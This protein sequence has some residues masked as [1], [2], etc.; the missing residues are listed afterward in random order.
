MAHEKRLEEEEAARIKLD[1]EFTAQ[2]ETKRQEAIKR[3]KK[4]QYFETDL[5]KEFHSR[6]LLMH[7]LQV[8]FNHL[9]F[10]IV[11]TY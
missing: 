6:T 5:V 9:L 3:A 2:E 8:Y 1:Q 4:L 11:I 10:L 7:V